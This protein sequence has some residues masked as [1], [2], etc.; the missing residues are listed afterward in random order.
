VPAAHQTFYAAMAAAIAG[1][2]PV[3]V[4]PTEARD[5][6]MVIEHALASARDGRVV[7]VA[8]AG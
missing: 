7:R 4:A 5:T 1:D 6:V 3:P 2:G 8:P